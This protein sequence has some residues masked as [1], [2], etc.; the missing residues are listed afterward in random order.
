MDV[1]LRNL[2]EILANLDE[3]L[4]NR[5]KSWKIKI[6]SFTFRQNPAISVSEFYGIRLFSIG[7]SE[8]LRQYPMNG[9]DRN[10]SNL[11]RCNPVRNSL[12]RNPMKFGSDP[13]GFYME[14][15]EIRSNPI[16]DPIVSGR[17]Y[18]SN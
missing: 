18:R 11:F 17:I 2:G 4:R 16:S 9:F 7:R 15:V 13:I 12:V 6:K 10:R 3:T 5:G 14:F 8:Q 1:I